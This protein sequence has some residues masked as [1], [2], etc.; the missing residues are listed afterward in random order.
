MCISE[1]HKRAFL[2]VVGFT[3]GGSLMFY[4]FTTY[5]QK[6]LVNT[7]GMDPKVANGV[8][9]GA[10]FVYM[11]L[12]PIFGAVSDTIGRRNSMPCFAFFGLPLIHF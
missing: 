7:A 6:Y 11:I 1:R 3:A 10:L 8:M 12:Q 5:M 2:N 9:T 4:T